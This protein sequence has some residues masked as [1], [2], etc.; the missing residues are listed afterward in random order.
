[1]TRE[2]CRYDANGTPRKTNIVAKFT[3]IPHTT[4]ASTANM[5][6]GEAVAQGNDAFAHMASPQ[7]SLEP[8]QVVG[9]STIMVTTPRSIASAWGPFLDKIKVFTEI[10]DKISEVQYRTDQ[11]SKFA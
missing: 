1:M 2:L 5:Q 11:F 10:V 3:I 6:M 9:I 4:F 7:S 8:Q